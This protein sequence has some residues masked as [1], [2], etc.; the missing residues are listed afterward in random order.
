MLS[1]KIRKGTRLRRRLRP[2]HQKYAKRKLMPPRGV[3]AAFLQAAR[4]QPA[5]NQE[6]GQRT[7]HIGRHLKPMGDDL[8][9]FKAS[10]QLDCSNRTLHLADIVMVGDLYRIRPAA[11]QLQH[12]NLILRPEDRAR[13]IQ[14]L[15]WPNLPIAA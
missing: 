10:V 12:D 15:L 4:P 2:K 7:E 8:I 1:A 3:Q 5:K 11:L 6:R 13:H 14:R 9:H